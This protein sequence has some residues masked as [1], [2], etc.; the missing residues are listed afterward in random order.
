MPLAESTLIFSQPIG[1]YDRC[2]P[3]RGHLV[4]QCCIFSQG[5]GKIM[6]GDP[7]LTSRFQGPHSQ[8]FEHYSLK[9]V[10]YCHPSCRWLDCL[11]A[12]RSV[13]SLY[14]HQVTWD[15]HFCQAPSKQAHL[16][17]IDATVNKPREWMGLGFAHRSQVALHLPHIVAR[18]G[19]LHCSLFT[20]WLLLKEIL[21]S[22]IVSFFGFNLV[23]FYH[24]VLCISR[25]A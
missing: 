22:Y 9:E 24:S 25:L 17:P 2:Y 19:I 18:L 20:Y 15:H 5:M 10:S 23:T 8:P 14:R 7:L 21:R 13:H 4:V 16:C 12:H 6:D 3:C 11:G 1:C